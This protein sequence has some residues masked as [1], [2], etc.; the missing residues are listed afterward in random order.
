M[1][2]TADAFIKQIDGM[3]GHFSL[4]CWVTLYHPATI[5]QTRDT[6]APTD[7]SADPI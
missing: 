4:D 3:L 1:V 6:I 7:I 2:S 5:E